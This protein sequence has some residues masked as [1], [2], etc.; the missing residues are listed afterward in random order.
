MSAGAPVS[1]GTDTGYN[2]RKNRWLARK[3]EPDCDDLAL[4]LD[5][6]CTFLL[7][8]APN[9]WRCAMSVP[10]SVPVVPVRQAPRLMRLAR[11]VYTDIRAASAAACG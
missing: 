6:I 9:M 3:Y 7:Y 1:G 11:G 5:G 10:A 2:Y 4:K 8:V